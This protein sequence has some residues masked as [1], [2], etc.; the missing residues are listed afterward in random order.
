PALS[1]VIL[2]PGRERQLAAEALQREVG[3][4]GRIPAAPR[5]PPPDHQG[6]FIG[7]PGLL[8]LGILAAAGCRLVVVELGKRRPDVPI[9]GFPE[10]QAEIDVIER[11]LQGFVQPP[12]LLVG[13]ASDDQAGTRDGG[14]LLR[15]ARTTAMAR[16]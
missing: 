14:E 12:Y 13:G 10:P 9:S 3:I 16:V 4:L 15:D 6:H 7:E 11:N 8:L 2:R 5:I 1:R